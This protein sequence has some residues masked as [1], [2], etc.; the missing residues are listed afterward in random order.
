MDHI[1][2]AMS[3]VKDTKTKIR[4]IVERLR[5]MQVQREAAVQNLEKRLE[6]LVLT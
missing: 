2:R 6:Q 4:G 5:S 3:E 1:E